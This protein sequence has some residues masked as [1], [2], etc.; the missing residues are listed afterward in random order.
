MKSRGKNKYPVYAV[1]LQKKQPSKVTKTK[2][3]KQKNIYFHAFL[4]PAHNNLWNSKFLQSGKNI[5]KSTL[6]NKRNR[7][8]IHSSNI[9]T[10][11]TKYTQK[12]IQL[13]PCSVP[14]CNLLEN[15]G[16]NG[17]MYYLN[18]SGWSNLRRHT[19]WWTWNTLWPIWHIRMGRGTG[20]LI[21]RSWWGSQKGVVR[22]LDLMI[23][24]VVHWTRITVLWW[25]S[26]ELGTGYWLVDRG[27]PYLSVLW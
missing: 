8:N 4:L 21:W 11:V 9:L 20:P 24:S 15:R 12:S 7:W 14:G 27:G 2:T 3:K 13:G 18:C 5:N 26:E 23:W 1:P 22:H 6:I 10:S 17:E 19:C 25:W 16:K